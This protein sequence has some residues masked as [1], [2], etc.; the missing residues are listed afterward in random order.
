MTSKIIFVYLLSIFL[1]GAVYAE[2]IPA[3]QDAGST[4]R[5]YIDKKK[6]EKA[7]K[8]LAEPKLPSLEE[9]EL[10]ELPDEKTSIYI[11]KIRIQCDPFV[12]G[13]KEGELSKLIEDYEDRI[14]SLEE[15]KMLAS[16]LT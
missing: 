15:I 10:E 16:I 11:Q 8:R 2:Q 9:I 12:K 4:V 7:V 14:L 13:Y 3:G 5:D 6:Q 1:C